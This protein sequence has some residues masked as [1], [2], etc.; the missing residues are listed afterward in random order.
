MIRI[1]VDVF[2]EQL[3]QG[4]QGIVMGLFTRVLDW[5]P[6]KVE[7]FLMDLRKE[8]DDP[9]Y[10]LLDHALVSFSLQSLHLEL[11]LMHTSYVVYGR[12]PLAGSGAN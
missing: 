5:T 2:A 9:T 7:L 12:K 11:L 4:L 10:H 3:K 1:D 8:L 6:T